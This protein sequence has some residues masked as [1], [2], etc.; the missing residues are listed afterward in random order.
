M[1]FAPLPD[2]DKMGMA[3]AIRG[4]SKHGKTYAANALNGSTATVFA[5][6]H[7]TNSTIETMKIVGNPKLR[8]IR[9]FD[10][11]NSMASEFAREFKPS[12][13]FVMDSGSDLVNLAQLKYKEDHNKP[14]YMFEWATVW[15]YIKDFMET[16]TH[17]GNDLIFTIMMKR[18]RNS[19]GDV[20]V[21]SYE[22][23]EWKDL[24]YH[25]TAVFRLQ[26]GIRLA[27]KLWF[28]YR[29]FIMVDNNRYAY[30][31]ESKPMIVGAFAR[32]N[33]RDQLQLK[34]HGT[35][36]D[37]LN[38]YWA[39]L[40][41]SQYNNDRRFVSDIEKLLDAEL[42]K[43]FQPPVGDR[44]TTPVQLTEEEV[45]ESIEEVKADLPDELEDEPDAE[46]LI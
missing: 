12:S 3:L 29:I 44:V 18:S 35:V 26:R 23:A 31:G 6:T 46:D 34:Y 39:L 15:G 32:Q 9:T 27:D 45:I 13:S 19:K 17:S 8:R 33:V 1:E 43:D 16:I 21:G 41:D 22:P 36:K 24:E 5:D 38:E 25:S 4:L 42:K 37:C 28:P 2:D 30:I 7:R 11:L 40:K 10:E 20:I 14:A